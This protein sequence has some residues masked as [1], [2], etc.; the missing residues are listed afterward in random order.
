MTETFYSWTFKFHKLVR[1]QN[2]GAAED[3]IYR[4]LRLIYESK[5]ERIIEMNEIGPHLPKLS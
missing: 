5:S 2:S 3:F 4:I 1:Q